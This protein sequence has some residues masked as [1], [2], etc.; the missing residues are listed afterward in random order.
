MPTKLPKT[1][2]VVVGV[3][4]TGGIIAA[5]LTK[6]GLKVVGLE[7]GK[8]RTTKDYYMVHDELRYAFHYELMQDLSRE[9][10][11]FRN[12]EQMR[13]LPMRRYGS[14]LP[15]E[16]LGGAGVHW[17]GMTFRF[18]PYDFQIYSKTVERY[19][20]NKI[21]DGMTIQDWGI[22]YDELEPYYD[23]F[24][25]MAGISGE[26]NPLGAK[27]SSPYP[28]PPMKETPLL[29]LFKQAAKSLNLHPY[30]SP[31]ANLSQNYTNPDGI[32]RVACQYCG[33]CERFGCEYGAKADPVVTVLP[34]AQKSGNFTLVTFANVLRI[35]HD[36]KTA[37]GVVYVDTRTGEEFEQPADIVVLTSYVLNNTRLLLLSKIGRPY[38]PHTGQGVIGKNYCYQTMGAAA[39]GFFENKQF[40]LFAGAG[41]LAMCLD[42]FNGDNFDHSSLKFIHGANISVSQTGLRPIANNPILPGTKSWGKDFKAQS[43]R[44]ANSVFSVGA[45]GASMPHRYHYLDLDPIYKDIYGQPLL[46]ITFDF[47]DQE[48]ELVAFLGQQTEKIAKAMGADKVVTNTK[49]G[50]YNIV[51]Y[52]STHNTGGVIMGADPRTSAVNHY[53]QMW[54]ME[55]LFVVG[56]SA[57]A[58]NSGYNPTGTVGALAYRAAEGILKYH[59]NGGSLA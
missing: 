38:D 32:S 46:R 39:Q 45:Q 25:K 11:T 31:S 18:L 56:A 21:P 6:Q 44:Y 51:P 57:F 36:G 48:R 15:G 17:N 28:N 5:E 37:A 7:R 41:A 40:N 55:N 14:F 13:A 30:M 33:F 8:E 23:K 12:N 20:K 19:G 22:T 26:E 9:T 59:K 58:H 29:T 42:D 1:D 16:N 24:E 4:W 52:Q 47:E 27:R 53:L 2:V 34:V 35:I 43:I 50:P 54:D 49:L 3:G 10:V